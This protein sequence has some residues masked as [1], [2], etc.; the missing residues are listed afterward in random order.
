MPAVASLIPPITASDF[1]RYMGYVEITSTCWLWKGA[2]NNTGYG[3]FSVGGGFPAAHRVLYCWLNGNPSDS[4]LT[5]D[6]LCRN[7]LCVNPLHLDLVSCRENVHRA[8]AQRTHCRRGHPL[9]G[10]N[11][12]VDK[13]GRRRCRACQLQRMRERHLRLHPTAKVRGPYQSG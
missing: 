3:H 10:A 12:R 8:V 7:R 11:E 2:Q 1:M 4:R 9:D 5:L 13:E 6:H